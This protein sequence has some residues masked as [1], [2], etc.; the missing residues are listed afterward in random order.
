MTSTQ[1]AIDEIPITGIAVNGSTA[2]SGQVTFSNSNSVSFGMPSAGVITASVNIPAAAGTLTLSISNNNTLGTTSSGT[3]AET[4]LVISAAGILSGG[5]NGNT[6][7]LSASSNQS[8]QT[9]GWTAIGNTTG[10]T[11]STTFNSNFS[12]SGSGGASVG[13]SGQTIQIAAPATS[14]LSWFASSNTTGATSSTTLQN[15]LTISGAGGVSVGFNGQTLIISGATGGGTGVGVF[16]AGASNLGNTA[17]T[18][19]MAASE[20]ILVGLGAVT[21]SQSLDILST[22]GTLS[23][24]VPT[25]TQNTEG[26]SAIGQTTASTSSTSFNSNFS[27]SGAGAVSVGFSGQSIIIS[28]ATA[29]ATQSWS[30]IGLTTASTSSTSFGPSVSISGTGGVSVGFSGQTLVIS[31]PGAGAGATLS[32]TNFPVGAQVA[33]TALTAFNTATIQ[34]QYCPLV[35]NLIISRALFP[36][37]FLPQT[38]AALST[39]SWSATI[40]LGFYTRN[41]TSLSL[42]SSST[43]AISTSWSSNASSSVNGPRFL[44]LPFAATLTPNEYWAALGMSTGTGGQLSAT[45]SMYLDPSAAWVSLG[46]QFFGSASSNTGGNMVIGVGAIATTNGSAMPASMA[47]IT[48]AGNLVGGAVGNYF[49]QLDNWSIT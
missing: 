12:I 20:L 35:Q 25:Q 21:L 17:G 5:L 27:I 14:A 36:I 41:G 11:S 47:I 15:N 30:A 7:I 38:S 39:G 4:N 33:G 18:T 40:A 26:W 3:L 46:P 34:V 13:F 19:G 37:S 49:L 24:S 42:Y 48:G 16:S 44:S 6:L 31:G 8:V 32:K 10:A 45:F 2:T 9:E 1:N 28:G 22:V 43:G 29:G 23:I